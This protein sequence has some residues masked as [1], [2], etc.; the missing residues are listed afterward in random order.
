MDERWNGIE[1]RQLG[2]PGRRASDLRREQ[3]I[4]QMRGEITRLKAVVEILADAVQAL[5]GAQ[6]KPLSAREPNAA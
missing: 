4:E 1:R 3:E 5:T 2:L 6:R